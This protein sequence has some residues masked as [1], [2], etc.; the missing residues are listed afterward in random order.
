MRLTFMIAGT[1]LLA[2]C[3]LPSGS[4]TWA[5]PDIGYAARNKARDIEKCEKYAEAH[6]IE[7][8]FSAA[9]SAHAYGGWGDFDF[10]FCMQERGWRLELR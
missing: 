3:A 6:Q 7:G 2:G 1:A 10:E 4:W 8:P 9:G 5:H